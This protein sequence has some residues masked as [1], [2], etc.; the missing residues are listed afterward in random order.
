M[1]PE[2]LQEFPSANKV[3]LCRALGISRAELY[4]TPAASPDLLESIEKIV[5]TLTGYGYRRTR[6]ALVKMGI[7]AS[8]H[9]VRKTMRENGLQARRPRPKPQSITKRDPAVAKRENLLR[10]YAPTQ[11]GEIWATDMTCIRTRSGA[12]YLAVM[13]DIYTRKIIAWRVSRSP[14]LAL[15]LACLEEALKKGKPVNGWIHHSDQGSVYTAP[16]YTAMVRAAGG[17]MSMS[18]SGT[19]TDNAFVESFFGTLKKEEVRGN[20][21]D[22]FLDLE[23]SLHRYIDGIYNAVR[24]HSSIGDLSPDEFEARTREVGQ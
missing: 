1:I 14:N 18:R 17:R 3:Q 22:S 15:A 7:Q 12:M 21:Y 16:A 2:L 13:E 20:D 6:K 24:M 19:P 8:E 9:A 23:T 5:T 10:Q 11:A 4:R